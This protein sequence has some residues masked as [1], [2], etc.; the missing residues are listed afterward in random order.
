MRSYFATYAVDSKHASE[1]LNIVLT[2]WVRYQYTEHDCSVQH[3]LDCLLIRNDDL[4]CLARKAIKHNGKTAKHL[5]WF[6]GA[7]EFFT[8]PELISQLPRQTLA[9]SW[10]RNM[11]G[12]LT[13]SYMRSQTAKQIATLTVK[14]IGQPMLDHPLDAL[15][16][17][18][19][20]SD[21]FR[22]GLPN[23]ISHWLEVQY[24]RAATLQ[25]AHD[26]L[27]QVTV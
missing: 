15:C 20:A 4:A 27:N 16:K 2:D 3:L 7:K 13:D 19:K 24:D 10:Q 5:V 22:N 17:T 8:A 21:S 25:Q 6:N 1:R 14:H 9:D 18:I 26:R 12:P 11:L 23:N